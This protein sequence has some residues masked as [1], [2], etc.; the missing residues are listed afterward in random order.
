MKGPIGNT[1]RQANARREEKK[2]GARQK[3]VMG[4]SCWEWR[5][6]QQVAASDSMG[7]IIHAIKIQSIGSLFVIVAAPVTLWQTKRKLSTWLFFILASK[8]IRIRAFLKGISRWCVLFN[9]S[10]RR[11]WWKK[12]PLLAH[13]D[14]PT[15][16]LQAMASAT[17]RKEREK[18]R[19]KKRCGF[20][21]FVIES[22]TAGCDIPND[23]LTWTGLLG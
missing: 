17:R 9:T 15:G 22:A 20:I 14:R 13:G 19:K 12:I 7:W 8:F 2:W 5:V 6:P 3:E 11:Q 4:S 1:T 16:L 23:S 21:M 18:E 10:R